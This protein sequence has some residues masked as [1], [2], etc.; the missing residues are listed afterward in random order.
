MDKPLD[1]EQSQAVAKQIKSKGKAS[2]ENAH[3]AALVTEDATYVQGF[4]VYEGSPFKPIEHSWL[5]VSD[6]LIDPSFPHLNRS[7]E[8]L[9]Y[10]PAQRLTAKQL[11]KAIE[12]AQEDYPEDDPLPIYG[13]APYEYYGD[14][15]LGGKDYVEAHQAAE[16]KCKELN[17]PKSRNGTGGEI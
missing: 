16:A 5:E 4:L 14:V 13:K 17:K 8:Q 1:V 12:D 15:M 7:A 11:K 10:F 6:R 3:R 2:F 9:F